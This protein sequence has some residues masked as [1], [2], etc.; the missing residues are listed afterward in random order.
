VGGPAVAPLT[1]TL[2]GASGAPIGSYVTSVWSDEGF[3]AESDGIGEGRVAL[4]THG[5]S[6]GGS[7]ALPPG[8]LGRQGTLRLGKVVYQYSSFPAEAYPSGPMHVF[9]LKSLRST[10][11]LCGRT[12][13][14]TLVNTLGGVA[15]LLYAGEAGR[16][17][18]PQV[19]RVEGDPALL[20]AVARSDAVAA[21]LAIDKLLNQH[22]VRLRVNAGG[23]LLAD[24]GGPYVLAPVHGALRAGGRRL[25]DFVLS[26]QDDEGY[27][28][29]AKRL[30]GLSVLMYMGSQL[31]KNSLGPSPGSVPDHGAY[32]YRGRSFRVVTLHVTAFPSGPLQIKV[33]IPI[34][35][36]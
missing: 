20:S 27:L 1:G 9:L 34:P 18:L 36:S 7:F 16:R 35:Y 12:G 17:T 2:T 23:K 28:R 19:R 26:I 30:V 5:R 22:I 6:V 21:R 11:G 13:E 15:R 3:I 4:H 8:K 29:L 25:G 10:A 24:V 31:V 14:D 33:L 32:V